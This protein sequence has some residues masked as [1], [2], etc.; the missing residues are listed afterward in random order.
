MNTGRNIPDYREQHL[1]NYRE[2]KT[3]L[4]RRSL[5]AGA[6]IATAASKI[7]FETPAKAAT[8]PP[9]SRFRA[10]IV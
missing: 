4:T 5:L 9:A 10:G 1:G 8:P 7:P 3:N 6:A 2:A